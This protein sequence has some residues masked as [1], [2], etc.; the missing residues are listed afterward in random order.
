MKSQTEHVQTVVIGGGQAGLSTGYFLARRGLPFVILD[1]SERV[2]D[3]WRNR[4]DSLRL[5]TPARFDSLAGMPFPAPP[6]SFPTKDQMADYLESYAAHFNLPVRNGVKV[7]RL[8]RQGRRYLITAGDRRFE[9][10]H[11]V[12][13]MANYQ[14]P[15]VPRFASELDR[16]IV[17]MHSRD[18]RNPR[19]LKEGGVLIVGA[20]NSGAEIGIELARSHRIWMAGRDTGHIPFRIGG[21]AAR[22]F[23]QR[24]VFRIVFHRLLTIHTPMGRKARANIRG[25]GAP[26]IRTRPADLTAAGIERVAKIAGVRDGL[27]LLEDGRVL[28]VANVIWCTGFQPGFSWIH[29]PIF[30]ENGRPKHEGGVV[31]GEPGLYFVGLPFIYAF[32]SSMIHGVGRDAARIVE[33]INDRARAAAGTMA[34]A[35]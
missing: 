3:A 25:K 2:G 23:L 35:A 33:M 5:F 4:W 9:A 21:L 28:D 32:S 10:E 26:L 8:S 30:D 18:Y 19:Q 20:G 7:D 31:S 17:Q 22:L 15:K 14:V 34:S 6:H 16:A 12:V 11:V 24:L 13:A 1:A 27:P 29:Q